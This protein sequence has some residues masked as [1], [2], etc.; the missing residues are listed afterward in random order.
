MFF[1]ITLKGYQKCL[2]D[3]KYFPNFSN[4]DLSM[5]GRGVSAP[6]WLQQSSRGTRDCERD[7]ASRSRVVSLSRHRPHQRGLRKIGKVLDI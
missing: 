5:S 3:I 1:S 7:N 6:A 2:S 4:L